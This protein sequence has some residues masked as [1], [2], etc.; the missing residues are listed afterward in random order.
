MLHFSFVSYRFYSYD[1]IKPQWKLMIPYLTALTL[2]AED[3]ILN[4]VTINSYIIQ[5]NYFQLSSN[6]LVHIIQTNVGYILYAARPVFHENRCCIFSYKTVPFT[7]LIKH[8]R[9]LFS[10]RSECKRTM[11]PF[12]KT[13]HEILWFELLRTM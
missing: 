7:W 5:N 9:W 6:L 1:F 8:I 10:R 2:L 3:N 12:E 11:W 4:R 13:T